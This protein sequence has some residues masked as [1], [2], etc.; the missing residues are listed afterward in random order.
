MNEVT[1]RRNLKEVPLRSR[2]RIAWEQLVG[3]EFSDTNY[4]EWEGPL[5]YKPEAGHWIFHTVQWPTSHRIDLRN[6][7][8]AH[9]KKFIK[10]AKKF[11]SVRIQ[12]HTEDADP[13]QIELYVLKQL[14]DAGNIKLMTPSLEVYDTR[15]DVPDLSKTDSV[16]I[17]PLVL[18]GVEVLTLASGVQIRVDGPGVKLSFRTVEVKYSSHL[19]FCQPAECHTMRLQETTIPENLTVLSKAEFDRC[20]VSRTYGMGKLRTVIFHDC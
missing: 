13:V 5:L 11:K 14:A 2:L 19:D 17:Q 1:L 16:V 15:S 7:D 3:Q 4:A 10:L 12:I 9:L 6:C 18:S 8:L 20:E